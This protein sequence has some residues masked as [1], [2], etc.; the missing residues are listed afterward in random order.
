[1][2]CMLKFCPIKCLTSVQ[3]GFWRMF[4]KN[5]LCENSVFCQVEVPL[6]CHV[7]S[8]ASSDVTSECYSNLL[9]Y[10]FQWWRFCFWM[11]FCFHYLL[12]VLKLLGWFM[13]TLYIERKHSLILCNLQNFFSRPQFE[14]ALSH[15]YCAVC[16]RQFSCIVSRN[17]D[18]YV[19][20]TLKYL[21]CI[22]CV[23]PGFVFFWYH[24]H[25]LIWID[26]SGV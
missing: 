11:P 13:F 20:L 5:T 19:K 6:Y 12:V 25:S 4:H 22:Y 23:I 15:I 7:D 3:Q 1:V 24:F 14:L 10:Y 2:F 17:T 16:Q 21:L 8:C 9:N 18:L 26:G